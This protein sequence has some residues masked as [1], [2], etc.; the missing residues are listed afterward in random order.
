MSK[1]TQQEAAYIEKRIADAGVRGVHVDVDEFHVAYLDGTVRSSN[2]E[3]AAVQ[4]AFDAGAP[5]VV[6]G[7]TYP[8]QHVVTHHIAAITAGVPAN[9]HKD[10][11][12][13]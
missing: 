4:A 2:D 11:D 3:A 13:H 1:V 7:L 12:S 6:D 10:K 5:E 8:G 9:H